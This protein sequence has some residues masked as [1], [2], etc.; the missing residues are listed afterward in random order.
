MRLN[1]TSLNRQKSA[2]VVETSGSKVV[3]FRLI[4][5]EFGLCRPIDD[6]QAVTDEGL[7]SFKRLRVA[8]V[9]MKPINIEFG[10]D[11]F[12]VYEIG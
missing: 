11:S 6:A 8:L 3:R 4:R 1:N 2:V 9:S 12:A 7:I 5:N 10:Y